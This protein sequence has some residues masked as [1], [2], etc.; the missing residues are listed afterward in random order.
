MSVVRWEILSTRLP[1]PQAILEG[2]ITVDAVQELFPGL[3]VEHAGHAADPESESSVF[4]NPHM[5]HVD[6][7]STPPRRYSYCALP[8]IHPI[9]FAPGLTFILYHPQAI[10]ES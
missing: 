8:V 5:V 3:M 9:E 4:H 2:E 1:V 10:E 7:A 6:I